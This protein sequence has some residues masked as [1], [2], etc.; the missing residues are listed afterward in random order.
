MNKYIGILLLVLL[1]S[2]RD[3][4]CTQHLR[5]YRVI[6]NLSSKF[7][8]NIHT[9]IAVKS[10]LIN[11]NDINTCII[12]KNR[13]RNSGFLNA[14]F[15]DDDYIYEYN[16]NLYNISDTS[17]YSLEYYIFDEKA[18]SIFNEHLHLSFLEDEFNNRRVVDTLSLTIDSTLLPIFKKDYSML[19]EF[20]EYYEEK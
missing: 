16:F 19:E 20:K 15:G 17:S 11:E 7:I 10:I 8:F 4:Y 5:T 14:Y 18:D 3:D 1:S 12:D 9:D 2:C 13:C 6:N